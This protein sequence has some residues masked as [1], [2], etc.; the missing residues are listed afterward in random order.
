MS[1]PASTLALNIGKNSMIPAGLVLEGI[2]NGSNKMMF[3]SICHL[4]F[5]SHIFP[6]HYDHLDEV[7]QDTI[8]NVYN[9]THCVQFASA[10]ENSE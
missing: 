10:F 5:P 3:C 2:Y 9:S 4:L 6:V 8:Q 1:W 7:Y